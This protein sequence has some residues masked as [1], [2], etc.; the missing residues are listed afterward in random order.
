MTNKKEIQDCPHCKSEL[1]PWMPPTA[2]SWG[3]NLQFVCFNDECSYYV[4][5]WKHMWD[6]YNVKSSYRHRF[7]PL[8]G[9][10]GPLPVWSESALKDRITL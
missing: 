10:T 5:G 7:D 6:Q 1:L 2:T 9:E 3:E 4:R 8:T